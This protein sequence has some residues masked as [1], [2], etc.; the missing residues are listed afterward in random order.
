MLYEYSDCCGKE[1]L[2]S[3]RLAE[4]EADPS[5]YCSVCGLP[6]IRK[7]SAPACLNNTREFQAFRSPV[8]GTIISSS[9]GLR[10]HNARNNVVN[11]HEGYD[12]KSIAGVTKKDF[13]KPLDDERRKDL[14]KDLSLSINKLQNGYTPQ[15]NPQ[16]DL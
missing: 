12:E 1:N 9:S 16:G 8:D 13:Q 14:S 11:I 2:R 3:C 5:M 4:Y 6:V 15:P 10:N 7:I